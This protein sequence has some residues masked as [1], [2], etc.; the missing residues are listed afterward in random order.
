MVHSLPSTAIR[1]VAPD[2]AQAIRAAVATVMTADEEDYRELARQGELAALLTTAWSGWSE[3]V[4]GVQQR[5]ADAPHAVVVRGLPLERAAH[6]LLAL[7]CCLGEV[8]EPYRQTWSRLVRR[9]APTTDRS[10]AAG[11]LNERLHTDG[12]DWPEPNGLTCLLCVRADSNGGGR[13]RLLPIEAIAELVATRPAAVR[14]VATAEL[15]WAVADELGGG[16]VHAPV[17]SDGA[18]RWLRFTIEQAL[19]CAPLAGS[20]LPADVIDAL[21]SFESA[22]EAAPGGFEFALRP[23]DLLLVNNVKCLHART[24]VSNP[25]QSD[26]LLLRTKVVA[27]Q[28]DAARLLGAR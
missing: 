15:P 10:G 18:V 12:T 1:L 26:R 23:G 8:V 14:S 11:V 25:Q 28:H 4:D 13:S 19:Q 22:L 20:T 9:I 21:R 5:F 7:S 27:H 2:E 17:F 3:L 16:V 6:T 24:A